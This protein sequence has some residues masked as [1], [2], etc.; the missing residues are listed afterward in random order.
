MASPADGPSPAQIRAR[1]VSELTAEDLVQLQFNVLG[2]LMA[3]EQEQRLN[4]IV[5]GLSRWGLR[6]LRYLH[7]AMQTAPDIYRAATEAADEVVQTWAHGRLATRRA[8]EADI[9][10]RYFLEALEDQ[11]S[12]ARLAA[13]IILQLAPGDPLR[14][15]Q[16]V[17]DS[18]ERVLAR[19]IDQ[20]S[21]ADADERTQERETRFAL[22]A[23]AGLLEHELVSEQRADSL[24]A[25]GRSL[26][27][28]PRAG[29]EADIFR[30][31]AATNLNR[32]AASARSRGEL[33][34]ARQL[35]SGIPALLGAVRDAETDPV[36]RA[37]LATIQEPSESRA[38]GIRESFE[39]I[40]AANVAA[41]PDDP[42]TL[43]IAPIAARRAMHDGDYQQVID[44]LAPLLPILED[45][46]LSAVVDQDVAKTGIQMSGAT[47][48]LAFAY[49]HTGD[50]G[51][52]IATLDRAKSLRFRYQALLRAS[53]LGS[54]L[55]ELE[56]DIQ[57]MAGGGMAP[58]RNAR[59]GPDEVRTL[60]YL[61][62]VYRGAR[63]RIGDLELAR[64]GVQEVA[65]CLAE[66]EAV[67]VL[68]WGRAERGLLLA[69]IRGSDRRVPSHAEI[70]PPESRTEIFQALMDVRAGWWTWLALQLPRTLPGPPLLYLLHTADRLV[71]A[72]SASLLARRD[73]RRVII[74]AHE[75]L[76]LVPWWAL[77]SLAPY[78]VM[79]ASSLGQLVAARTGRGQR[80]AQAEAE[81]RA[82][83]VANPT[84]DLPLTAGEAA[85]VVG[86]L[87][88]MGCQTD[89]VQAEGAIQSELVARMPSSAILHFSGHGRS[90]QVT[91]MRSALELSPENASEADAGSDLL[92]ELAGSAHWRPVHRLIGDTWDT[93][94]QERQADIPERGRLEEKHWP[95]SNR[96]EL[97]LE[98]AG[99]TLWGRYALAD[100]TG[101]DEPVYG[102]RLRISGLW[103]AG[104]MLT[105]GCFEHCRLAFLS[106]CE[107]GVGGH[108]EI[109]E[110]AGLPAALEVAGVSTVISPLW[111]VGSDAA[112]IAAE[113]FYQALAGAGAE[114][115][116]LA[117]MHRVRHRLR[118]M[119]SDEAAATLRRIRDAAEE[120]AARF[121]LEAASWLLLQR[122]EDYP[123]SHP[124]HWAAFQVTGAPVLQ[125]PFA[126]SPGRD[127]G[128]DS[129]ADPPDS[130]ELPA[131][132]A[133]FVTVGTY[134]PP[135]PF[136]QARDAETLVAATDN[137]VVRDMA[138]DHVYQRGAAYHRSGELERAAADYAR[139]I[140]LDPGQVEARV[141]LARISTARGD[142]AG[143]L[144]LT[145]AVLER[146]PDHELARLL[147][148]AA[149]RALGQLAAARAD[150]DHVLSTGTD[151]RVRPTAHRIRA[152]LLAAEGEHEAALGD[153]AEAIRLQPE[154]PAPYLLRAD[155]EL[156]LE[157]PQAAVADA[158]R[159]LFLAPGDAAAHYAVACALEAAG[160]QAE[161]VAAFEH[162]V[163]LR[164]GE[165]AYHSSLGRTLSDMGEQ[166]RALD[167][168]DLALDIGPPDAEIYMNRGL[169]HGAMGDWD[170]ALQDHQAALDLDPGNYAARY[171]RACAQSM[172][173]Q[174]GT[175][176]QDL[177]T[178]FA[179]E[180]SV[181]AHA[182]TD[183][184]L[185]WARRHLPGVREL[186]ADRR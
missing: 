29:D 87:R 28:G 169:A 5:A 58:N 63:E 56:R 107:A 26:S 131:L 147:R 163:E 149:H 175:V 89:L 13:R 82:L 118:T 151:E 8:D 85:R 123:F 83:V 170:R 96:I 72:R 51:R 186:L 121:Q 109:D 135:D 167:S 142:D 166:Q 88:S 156:V 67:V 69:I 173:G 112:A 74:V 130:F 42:V 36:R 155:I 145:D 20:A 45:R 98:Q 138:A 120:P 168:F 1:L 110:F 94:P 181:R 185:D 111:P 34:L 106:A 35:V 49:A 84:G 178:V 171:N 22:T 21:E 116:V 100:F 117:L 41:G 55:R 39:E 177:A 47:V 108:L 159:A 71:G 161:A 37:L 132:P 162:A 150:L 31:A 30:L 59:G 80:S 140:E 144:A 66:D 75:L 18:L 141:G 105:G 127:A 79:M 103:T 43:G 160:R 164:P 68:G 172:M 176:L 6:Y 52:A 153:L 128:P 9:R 65:R 86:H 122:E 174:S 158:R 44:E 57:A 2:V 4:R 78:E 154:E 104:E 62:E 77:P 19:A 11:P 152:Q 25:V 95:L 93:S 119:T 165:Q 136:E 50:F 143:A 81:P 73:V 179:Q 53:P 180:P 102:A 183:S 114:V 99:Q 32:R 129:A 125:L 124:Y 182:L 101:D 23:I 157:R 126:R 40:L 76:H 91:P 134:E 139:A 15:E 38:Q 60:P 24:I 46:Y 97:R 14:D 70:L 148:G 92:R 133:D 48:D 54:F 90:D 113:L 10:A 12:L 137:S 115:D 184:D 17:R 64:P 61:Q 27:S 3:P 16:R 146:A 7:V 33:E